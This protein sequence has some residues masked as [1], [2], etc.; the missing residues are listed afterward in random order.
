M[1]LALVFDLFGDNDGFMT[2]STRCIVGAK[3]G[4]VVS[5]ALNFGLKCA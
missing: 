4:L 5:Y 3:N 1:N 2:I